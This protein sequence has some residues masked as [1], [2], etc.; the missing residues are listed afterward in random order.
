MLHVHDC[1]MNIYK[2]AKTFKV[3]PFNKQ[4]NVKCAMI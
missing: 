4:V 3:I 1:V 2:L